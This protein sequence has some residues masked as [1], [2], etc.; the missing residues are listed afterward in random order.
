MAQGV[1]SEMDL[2]GLLRVMQSD[3]NPHKTCRIVGCN[4]SM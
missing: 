1:P 3:V 2:I 4:I